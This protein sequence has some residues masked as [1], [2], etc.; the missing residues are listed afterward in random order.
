MVANLQSEKEFLDETARWLGDRER[1]LASNLP[2]VYNELREVAGI[3]LRRERPG[4]TLQPTALVHE[5]YLRLRDQRNVDWNNRA[6]FLG[7]AARMMRRILV[8]HAMARG[9]AKR[10]GDAPRVSLDAALEIFQEQDLSTLAVHKALQELEALD[11]RQARI[12][13]M[14]FFGGLTVNEIADVLD[15]APITVKREWALAKLWLER[16]MSRN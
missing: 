4:H 13:E 7:V 3:Y 6:Q 2:Q 9:A 15:V 8:D 16:E 12:V 5:A 14:R 11:P 1:E 10:G